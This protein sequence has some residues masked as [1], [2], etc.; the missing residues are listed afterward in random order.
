[1]ATIGYLGLGTMGGGMVR[2]LV[3]A[4][5]DVTVWNRSAGRAD[6]LDGVHE[7]TTIAEAVTGRDIVMAC[8]S[9]DT[10]VREV[11]LGADG[12][13]AHVD[14]SSIVVD[15]STISPALADE[16]AAAFAGRDVAFLD[17]PVFGSRDEAA[18]GGLWVVA[19]GD[20]AT[21]ERVRPVLEA[22]SETVHHMGGAGAGA[23]MKLV[24]NAVVAAQLM[25]LGESLTLAKAAGLDLDR[26]LG[27]LAV[28]DF[29]SPIFDGVG[30][31]VLDD[32]YTPAFALDLMAKDVGLIQQFGSSVGVEMHGA[33]QA[34]DTLAEAQAQGFGQE[35]AS[36]LI[37]VIA[38]HGGVRLAR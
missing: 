29:R 34:A 22:V 12:V 38:N 28:T 30:P 23:R 31:T 37:K 24:G 25:A 15:M 36:A 8:L 33:S 2:N 7:A 10:A 16:E 6:G 20:E 14:P 17:A 4:G 1:M 26:V 27:V 32:D 9:D 11:M 5:H 18:N 13:L 3:G 21:Y 35:N 19:G